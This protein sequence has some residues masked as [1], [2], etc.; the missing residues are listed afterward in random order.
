MKKYGLII[1][2][3]IVLIA[4]WYFFQQ[5]SADTDT[6]DN[7]PTTEVSDDVT[8]DDEAIDPEVVSEDN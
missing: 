2:V 3:V 6:V 1:L 7:T 4:V 8:V 5:D